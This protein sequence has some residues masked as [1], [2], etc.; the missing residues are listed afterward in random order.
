MVLCIFCTVWCSF[1]L[2]SY[3]FC[4]TSCIS[5]MF[6]CVLCVLHFNVAN[7]ERLKYLSVFFT[8]FHKY[9]GN[10][11]ALKNIQVRVQCQSAANTCL[12]S[13]TS[14]VP[15]IY[16]EFTAVGFNY[17]SIIE[18]VGSTSLWNASFGLHLNCGQNFSYALN[19]ST[20]SKICDVTPPVKT[21]DRHGPKKCT[22]WENSNTQ[23]VCS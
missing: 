5:C 22:F 17:W 16:L 14:D 1:C 18:P 2:V 19:V 20:V 6:F 13:V 12:T 9:H 7:F 4:T 8:V 11:N 23:I 3:V 10:T 15:V 21:R